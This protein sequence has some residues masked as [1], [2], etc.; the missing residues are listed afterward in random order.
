LKNW[1]LSDERFEFKFMAGID[2]VDEGIDISCAMNIA[3]TNSN[4]INLIN[5]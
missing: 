2:R 3:D 5:I 1:H 4:T